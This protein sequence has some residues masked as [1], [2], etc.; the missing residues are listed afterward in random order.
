VEGVDYV[1]S[2]AFRNTSFIDELSPALEV[3][4]TDQS[5]PWLVWDD[6]GTGSNPAAN[7]PVTAPIPDLIQSATLK[8]VWHFVPQEYIIAPGS[9]IPAKIMAAV[10]CVN[11]VDFFGIPAGCLR[12]EA[13]MFRKYTQAAVR[14]IPSNYVIPAVY[15]I[16]LPF[17]FIDPP[18]GALSGGGTSTGRGW[19][20]TVYSNTG[21]WYKVKRVDSGLPYFTGYDMMKI[22]D[23]VLKP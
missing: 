10:G 16:V 5:A 19:N 21:R 20:L 22:F 7:A 14:V 15:D 13:P 9:Y 11:S 1:L 2:E 3:L 23:H 12:L 6:T 4:L 17:R 18:P 8:I